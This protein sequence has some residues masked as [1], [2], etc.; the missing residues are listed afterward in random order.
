MN[1]TWGI[2]KL[3][4]MRRKAKKAAKKLWRDEQGLGTLEIILIV[5]LIVVIAVAFR[6]W[7]TKWINDLFTKADSGVTDFNNTGITAP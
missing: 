7:I 1:Q 2:A 5:A 3:A 6:K 4:D